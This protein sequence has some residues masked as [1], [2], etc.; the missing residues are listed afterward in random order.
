MAPTADQNLHGDQNFLGHDQKIAIEL[1]YL[2]LHYQATE[3]NKNAGAK[4]NCRLVNLN[5]YRAAPPRLCA[6]HRHCHSALSVA[7]TLVP[8]EIATPLPW[9]IPAVPQPSPP[10]RRPV[11][12]PLLSR[13]PP[14]LNRSRVTHAIPVMNGAPPRLE[15]SSRS[16]GEVP[17]LE[18]A[19]T[20]VSLASGLLPVAVELQWRKWA[21]RTKLV[22]RNVAKEILFLIFFYWIWCSCGM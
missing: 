7:A 3:K 6:G 18:L 2:G 14:S 19:L 4:P 15:P 17:P 20:L 11:W 22:W 9:L 12:P 16:A 5:G 13:Y 1:V 10:L 8:A 21:R